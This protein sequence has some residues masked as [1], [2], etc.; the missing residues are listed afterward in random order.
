MNVRFDEQNPKNDKYQDVDSTVIYLTNVKNICTDNFIENDNLIGAMWNIMYALTIPL[1]ATIAG[2][3]TV[4]DVGT[5]NPLLQSE[6]E[7]LYVDIFQLNSQ[8]VN[9]LVDNILGYN[10]QSTASKQLKKDLQ[11]IYDNELKEKN[12]MN[13]EMQA[14]KY[15][16]FKLFYKRS[17]NEV[18]NRYRDKKISAIVNYL[19]EPENVGKK[20]QQVIL[21]KMN[22]LTSA[23]N[24]MVRR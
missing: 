7:D 10:A 21:E 6:M 3:K 13:A 4:I 8:E 9:E 19:N 12:E 24:K 18:L 17:L 2:I 15:D 16:G 1:T 22:A 23:G 14:S 5:R 11:Q 20:M